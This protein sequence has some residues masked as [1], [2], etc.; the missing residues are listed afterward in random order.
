MLTAALA[1]PF[2]RLGRQGQRGARGANVLVI[3]Y[4][5]VASLAAL[6]TLNLIFLKEPFGRLGDMLLEGSGERLAS[7]GPLFTTVNGWLLVAP[8]LSAWVI[9]LIVRRPGSIL[10]STLVFIAILASYVAGLLPAGS[11]GN[12]FILMS[13]MALAL[14]PTPRRRLLIALVDLV[15]VV[16]IVIAWSAA[17]NRPIVVEWMSAIAGGGGV[18]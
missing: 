6:V 18:F 10:V 4:P 16:Q 8:V 14:I 9:A 17:F 7:L 12:T 5:T 15:A 1:A 11:A 2:L 3:V 13:L